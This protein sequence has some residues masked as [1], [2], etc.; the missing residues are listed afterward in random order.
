MIDAEGMVDVR[1]KKEQDKRKSERKDRKNNGAFK[2]QIRHSKWMKIN[3]LILGRFSVYIC[4]VRSNSL[5]TFPGP[6]F[7][8]V[9][10]RSRLMF[11]FDVTPY[12]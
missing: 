3:R 6:M 5:F 12:I 2:H 4:G 9:V 10:V 1:L 7:T 8:S 11:T